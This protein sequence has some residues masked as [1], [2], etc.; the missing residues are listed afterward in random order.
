M[1]PCLLI[2]PQLSHPLPLL[3][4]SLPKLKMLAQWLRALVVLTKDPG[5]IPSTHVEA[6]PFLGHEAHVWCIDIH[7]GRTVLGTK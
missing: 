6:H 1:W 5:S 2:P 7:A 4:S 3:S